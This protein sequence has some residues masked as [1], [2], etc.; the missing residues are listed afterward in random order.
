MT[1]TRHQTEVWVEEKA[2]VQILREKRIELGLSQI[3]V[4]RR[5]DITRAR[6]A[7]IESGGSRLYVTDMLMLCQCYGIDVGIVLG[8]ADLRASRGEFG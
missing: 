2:M 7:K 3:E 4:S 5:A 6:L 1:E 8:A